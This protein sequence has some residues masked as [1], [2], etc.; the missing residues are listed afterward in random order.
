MKLQI[1][2]TDRIVLINGVPARVWEGTTEGGVPCLCFVTRVAVRND[3]DSSEFER[4]LLEQ[5]PPRPAGDDARQFHNH[6]T[7]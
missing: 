6:M 1:E 2:S 3:R 7:L 4:E 5:G